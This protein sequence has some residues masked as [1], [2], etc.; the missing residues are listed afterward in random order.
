M[1]SVGELTVTERSEE[2]WASAWKEHY[3]PFRASERFV[4]R[5]PWFDYIAKAN[6]IVLVLDPGMAFGTGMH[7][8]TR[9]S[10]LQ[11]EKFVKSGQS[12]LDVGT[13]SG[14]LALAAARMGACPIDAVDVEPMSIRVARS[15]LDL[16]NAGDAIHLA[17]GSADWATSQA[18]KYE[19]V[20]ANI[21]ARILISMAADLRATMVPGGVL[22]MSG[23]I[24]PK[25]S[26]TRAAF[27]DLDLEFLERN[28]TEDWI[29]LA[30]RAPG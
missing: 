24:E 17:I 11:I 30:Y 21:I 19:V 27:E 3:R 15:N 13:G 10:L 7:P 5:P 1:R 23:I 18:R 9:L 6:D 12:L 8:T 29:S 4:I 16:N 22:L 25:E 14:I 28:Q 2:D 20:V 26:E